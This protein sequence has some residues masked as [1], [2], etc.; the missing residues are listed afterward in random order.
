M[1]PPGQPGRRVYG[2]CQST[3]VGMDGTDWMGIHVL[4]NE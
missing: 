3:A 1:I 4:K 2:D